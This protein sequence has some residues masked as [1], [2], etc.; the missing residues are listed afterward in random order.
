MTSPTK[1]NCDLPNVW[2]P[3]SKIWIK[4]GKMK[5]YCTT[6][7]PK[8]PPDK[9]K[10]TDCEYPRLWVSG[11][12]KDKTT[13]FCATPILRSVPRRSPKTRKPRQKSSPRSSPKSR[14][15]RQKSSPKTRKPR[16]KSSPKSRKPRQKSSPSKP[17]RYRKHKQKEKEQPPSSPVNR[18]Y[19]SPSKRNKNPPRR[20]S[21]SRARPLPKPRLPPAP[22][23]SPVFKPYTSPPRQ[24]PKN[25]EK[26]KLPKSRKFHPTNPEIPE[27]DSPSSPRPR[28]KT[29]PPRPRQK[30]S[31]PRP[32]QKTSSPRPKQKTSSPRPKQKTPLQFFDEPDLDNAQPF[33]DE[34][35]PDIDSIYNMYIKGR[36][37]MDFILPLHKYAELHSTGGLS[38]RYEP[39]LIAFNSSEIKDLISLIRPLSDQLPDVTSFLV[40]WLQAALRQSHYGKTHAKTTP[41]KQQQSDNNWWDNLPPP[42]SSTPP[43]DSPKY[44]QS[45]KT[46][47]PPTGPNAELYSQFRQL[48][49]DKKADFLKTRMDILESDCGLYARMLNN[50]I[51]KVNTYYDPFIQKFTKA[52]LRKMLLKLHP[53]REQCPQ[54]MYINVVSWLTKVRSLM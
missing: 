44:G 9:T 25:P 52:D 5:G 27:F 12:R 24:A 13:G 34:S 19:I 18:N 4:E 48:S 10:K 40:S 37:P 14:K 30:T 33:D 29:S 53:D 49:N 45:S 26:S 42:P 54:N 38:K 1:T 50:Y 43:R 39:F 23:T 8:F 20:S 32:R 47:P 31:P 36:P 35:E 21:P 3:G 28:Q 22:P 17:R 51:G 7:D 6:Q 11:N 16:Q 2:I 46:T 41:P 15:P